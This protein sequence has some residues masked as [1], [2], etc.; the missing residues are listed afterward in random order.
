L[1]VYTKDFMNDIGATDNG[2]L[3]Q[4]T[5]NTEVAGTLGTYAGLGNGTSVSEVGSLRAPSGAQ[6]VRG[7]AS[8]DITRDFFVTDIPWDGYIVDRIDIQRGPNSILFGLGS[9]AG[10]INA[11][12]HNAE[13]R[14]MGSVETRVGSY[15][16]VRNS[17]DINQELIQNVLSVHVDG[18]WNDQK[19]E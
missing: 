4:Y 13:F 11:S 14:N 6:R 2:S 17:V 9:P 18:L 3:L 16:T 12:I 1:S 15:G 8:A 10:I 7:L 19:Y 5:T